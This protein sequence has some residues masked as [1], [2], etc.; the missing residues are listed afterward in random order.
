MLSTQAND[1]TQAVFYKVLYSLRYLVYAALDETPTDRLGIIS[2]SHYAYR[3]EY[4]NDSKV[5]LHGATK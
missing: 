5:S 2:G 3:Y 1:S 4:E